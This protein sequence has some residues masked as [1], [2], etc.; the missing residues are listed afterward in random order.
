MFKSLNVTSLAYT[1]RASSLPDILSNSER[2]T[3]VLTNRFDLKG[4]IDCMWKSGALLLL[5]P[6]HRP[7]AIQVQTGVPLD[8][9]CLP[10]LAMKAPQL[11]CAVAG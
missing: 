5:N 3:V 7:L 2:Q 6:L 11:I 9:D 8:V 10:Y 1:W 4:S